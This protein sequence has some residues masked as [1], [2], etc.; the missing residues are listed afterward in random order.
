MMLDSSFIKPDWQ[1]PAHVKAF[2]TTRIGGVSVAAYGDVTGAGGLN[3]AVH[4][5]DDAEHVVRNRALIR[6]FQH[7]DATQKGTF[8]R[9]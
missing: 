4:V 9:A 1:A 5:G 2:M 3:P 7:I 6:F 8:A